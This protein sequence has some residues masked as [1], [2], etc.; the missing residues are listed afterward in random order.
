LKLAETFSFNLE[1]VP[2]YNFE[3]T[4]HKPAGWWWSTP[5]E[6]FKDRVCWTATRLENALLG[7]KLTSTGTIVKPKI[8]C[9]VF[10]RSKTSTA[11]R[12]GITRM[13]KRALK[14]EE[15]PAEFYKL[16]QKDEILRPIVKELHGMRT[17]AWPELFPALILAV[18][19]QMAPMKR[20]NQMMELLLDNFGEQ[21]QFDGKN[22]RYWP[23]AGKTSGSSETE[24]RGKAKLGYRALN[25][26]AIARALQAGFPTMDE[27]WEMG[28]E[29]AK[30]KLLTLRGIGEYSAELVMP[31]MGFPLDVWSAKIFNVL[32][33]GEEPEK[34]REAIPLLKAT[35]EK[36]WGAW[37]GTA[38]VFILNDLPR[39]SKRV[40]FDLTKF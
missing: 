13:M 24:L 31:L 15:N 30:N 12:Q 32:F 8:R 23:S 27:L 10:S 21:A 37:S 6:I 33:F 34:P 5:D 18:T 39:I 25:L 28:P 2:P 17:V 11:Q 3:L 14:T 26:I 36:R 7:L 38:F 4:V 1:P 40:G 35:A 20:S 16:A 29:E 22:M 19:L 9:T